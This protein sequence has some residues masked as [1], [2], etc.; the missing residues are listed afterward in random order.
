MEKLKIPAFGESK[1]IENRENKTTRVFVIP[2]VDGALFDAY[3]TLLLENGYVK[4]EEYN[5][6]LH[7]LA[8]YQKKKNAFFLNYFEKTRELYIVEEK[9]SLYFSFSDLSLG[10]AVTPEI[11]QIETVESAMSYAIRLSDG[12]FIVIDGAQ[13]FKEHS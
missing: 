1:C 10:A 9:D 7:R 13:F 6:T 4:K 2:Q 8:A 3:A 11:T 5:R 12:R